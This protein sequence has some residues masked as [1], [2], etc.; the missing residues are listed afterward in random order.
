MWE[1]EILWA[2]PELVC[3]SGSQGGEFVAVTGDD[4]KPNASTWW[5]ALQFLINLPLRPLYNM[6]LDLAYRAMLHFDHAGQDS[7]RTPTGVATHGTT[8]SPH[9]TGSTLSA[10][11]YGRRG[12]QSLSN[13]RG[14]TCPWQSG[15]IAG[16]LIG[17]V[18]IS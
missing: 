3:K 7:T 9:S 15:G 12:T 5:R 4:P 8:N 14:T 17:V 11:L 16:I 13:C 18:C 2:R 6:V 1:V 10:P